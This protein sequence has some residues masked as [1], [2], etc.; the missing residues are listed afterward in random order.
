MS[1]SN[2]TY[3]PA[4]PPDGS[5]INDDQ[6]GS[7]LTTLPAEAESAYTVEEYYNNQSNLNPKNK[8]AYLLMLV[9]DVDSDFDI[10]TA[11]PYSLFIKGEKN[12]TGYMKTT[13]I[14]TKSL[15]TN[16][17]KRRKVKISNLKNKSLAI[18]F[19]GLKMCPLT[20]EEI[21]FV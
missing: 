17:L 6:V 20:D 19:S 3:N 5:V 10:S 2:N 15:V 8:I 16:E 7:P 18:C 11:Y 14:Y 4:K 9:S 1:E 21:D 13:F 12:F